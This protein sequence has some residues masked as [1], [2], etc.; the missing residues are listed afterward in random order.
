MALQQDYLTVFGTVATNAYIKITR[1]SGDKF[2]VTFDIRVY[3]SKEAID[4]GA[5]P[6]ANPHY[7]IPY[8]EGLDIR[9]MYLYLKTTDLFAGAIDC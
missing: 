4:S 6:L 7:K 5:V 8:A 2:E 3:A 9:Q 1:Y